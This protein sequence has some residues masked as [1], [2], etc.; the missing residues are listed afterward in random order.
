MSVTSLPPPDA[1]TDSPSPSSTKVSVPTRYD[2]L[3][4]AASAVSG[5]ETT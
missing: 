1:V 5:S 3:T 4:L 2:A